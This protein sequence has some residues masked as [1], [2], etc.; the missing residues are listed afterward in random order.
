MTTGP[1]VA[2]GASAGGPEA[3]ATLL[4]VIPTSFGGSIVIVQHMDVRFADDLVAWLSTQSLLPIRTVRSG[5]HPMPG[6]VL[7]AAT[8]DHL[9]FTSASRLAYAAEPRNTS[10]RPSV[11]VFFRSIQAYWRGAA[12][13]VLLTGMGQDGAMG[14]RTLRNAGAV[15]I[16][17]DQAS[18]VV[19]GMPK[20]AHELDAAGEILP[21]LDIGPRLVTLVQGMLLPLTGGSHA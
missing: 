12:I 8:N 9:V 7:L 2:I 21:L 13:G 18:S 10:S 1:L 11:D 15:T 16:A 19:Y 14:L 4:R 6:T 3:L 5:D 17:Q 20:A